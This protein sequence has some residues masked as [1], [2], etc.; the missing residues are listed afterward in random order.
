MFEMENPPGN[1]NLLLPVHLLYG[2]LLPPVPQ[3]KI[4][5]SPVSEKLGPGDYRAYP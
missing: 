4:I 2:S 3:N 5:V 1:S